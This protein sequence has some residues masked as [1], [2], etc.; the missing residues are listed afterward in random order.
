MWLA[1]T[2]E[3]ILANIEGN[4]EVI[5]VLDGEWASPAIPQHP[6]VTVIYNPVS[7]GQREATNQA[8][9]VS[10]AKYVMKTDA[11]CAFDKGFDVKLMSDMEDDITMVPLMRN[12]HVF[13][14]VCDKG[15]RRYQGPSGPCHECGAET[16]RDVV[17]IPKK[18]PV[19]SFYRF[20]NT[21]HFQYWKDFEKR[22]EGKGDLAPSM[23]IQGSCFLMTR[24][25]YHALNICDKAHGSWGQQGVEVACKTWLSGGRVMINKKT[26]YAHLFRTQGGDFGFPYPNTSIEHARKF[27]RDLWLND[28]WPLAIHK[29]QWLL[30]KFSPVPGWESPKTKSIVYYTC[31]T[32]PEKIMK[33]AQEILKSSARGLPIYTV[34]LKKTDF[35]IMNLT[36]D[37][38]RGNLT[39]FKQIL[40]GLQMADTDYVFLC[41]HDVLYHQSHFDFTPPTDDKVY[42]NENVW[43]LRIPDGKAVHYP[44]KQVSGICAN[45]EL[46]IK[47][48]EKRIEMVENNGFSMKMG[49]EP[50]T[51][52]R[53]ERV[54]DL[55]SQGWMSRRPNIDIRHGSNLSKSKWSVDDFRNKKDAEG[56][57][58]GD[59]IPGWGLSRELV[60]KMV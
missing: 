11:H 32:A 42:Y 12:L 27:S 19:S 51:H 21:L 7:V 1:R 17:W 39:M 50:G 34:A 54:D 38:E 46:L 41:E 45:R 9:R 40:R 52:N 33:Q 15:H 36:M 53:K 58:E 35:G 43:K 56:W 2:I 6:R 10:R 13:D 55:T 48:Y 29:F 8:A 3:D 20:D 37:M 26:W 49:Y 5:A 16:V 23:S 18:S 47:H 25:R 57:I 24:E 4:T 31:N 30:D 28:K 60:K 59:E 44:V 14:W 22:P